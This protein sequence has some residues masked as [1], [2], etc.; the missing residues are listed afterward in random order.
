MRRADLTPMYL[1]DYDDHKKAILNFSKHDAY[2][3]SDILSYGT[4]AAGYFW[5]PWLSFPTGIDQ[6]QL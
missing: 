3:A 5:L 4:A 1:S 2:S 6:K